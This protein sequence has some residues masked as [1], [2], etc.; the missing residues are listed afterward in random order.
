M[1]WRCQRFGPFTKAIKSGLF[2]PQWLDNASD[3]GILDTMLGISRGFSV[4]GSM[5]LLLKPSPGVSLVPGQLPGF[6]PPSGWFVAPNGSSSNS[7]S[8]ASPWSLDYAIAGAG[9]Q[10]LPG[11][12]VWLRGGNY[13]ISTTIWQ[14]TVN[15]LP[16]N[17][18]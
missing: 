16:N 8:I 3:M 13:G 14:W 2:L 12:T 15:G 10:V 11:Q 4:R 18:V 17:L 5:D 9:G 1:C 6:P 7:G